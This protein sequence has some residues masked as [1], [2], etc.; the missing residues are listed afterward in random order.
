MW[1]NEDF[2]T[3]V[4]LS[5]SCKEEERKYLFSE[6]CNGATVKCSRWS[7]YCIHAFS[8]LNRIKAL[9]KIFYLNLF[10]KLLTIPWPGGAP[11]PPTPGGLPLC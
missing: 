6:K 5:D 1:K 8:A 11:S 10:P 2:F 7:T 4:M 3:P 9:Q